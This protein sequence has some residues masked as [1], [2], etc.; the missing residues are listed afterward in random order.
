MAE[1]TIVRQTGMGFADQLPVP[2]PMPANPRAEEYKL[3]RE[4]FFDP[5]YDGFGPELEYICD[6]PFRPSKDIES[7]P[8][9]VGFEL[10]DHRTGY[11]FDKVLPIAK[12]S[13]IKWARLQ[14]GWQRAE[15]VPGVYNFDWLDE[16]VDGLRGVGIQPWF[17]LGFGNGLYM[18]GA[19]PIPPHGNYFFSPTRFGEKGITGWT[20]YCKAMVEHFKDRVFH[21]EVWN[22]P[23]AGFLRQVNWKECY[24]MGEPPEVYAQL[25]K[26]TA[27][28]VRS[29]QPEAKILAGSIS[30][31]AICNE[32]IQGLFDNG[33]AEHIDVF[34]YHPYQ[35]MP[36]PAYPE[37][38]Q[39]IRDLIAKS[40]KNITLWMG[41]NGR[42]SNSNTLGR[43]IR[44]TE[45]SQAKYLTRRYLT[46]L[47]M[48]MEVSSYFLICDIGNGYLPN[49]NVHSQGVIDAT[50]PEN[51]RPKLAFRAMQSFAN[52]F[53]S[54]TELI[55]ACFELA[56][57][58]G[59]W[60]YNLLPAE[61]A[62]GITCGF[63]RGNIPIFA[64]YHPTC[65]DSGWEVKP[66]RVSTYVPEGMKFD[67]PI[68]IDPITARVYRIKQK[69]H[70]TDGNWGYLE[71]IPKLP[72]LDYPLFVTD[73]SLLDELK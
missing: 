72:L 57:A 52:L 35:A 28:A 22:E 4:I 12:D 69:E 46:D 14:S 66:V 43:G 9:G 8:L 45:A 64:Y 2:D 49:G 25:V 41:E 61:I 37:R 16:I 33:I 70:W 31:C 3:Y 54:K 20:N 13:G 59:S 34:T 44:S 56:P 55:N 63:R 24:P 27:E 15:T 65:I 32:Y 67:K 42:P 11:I 71:V 36:E 51:Y 1:N 73:A 30:G 53:D 19:V 7:S 6:L 17:S 48:G 47:R 60:G 5:K 29:V 18:D 68:L 39:F 23:N 26:I 50:N 58:T 62:T 40:G 21:W 10:L 38:L